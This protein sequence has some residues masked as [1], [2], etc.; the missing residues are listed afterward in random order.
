MRKL[1]MIAALMF[2]CLIPIQSYAGIGWVQVPK[3]AARSFGYCMNGTSRIFFFGSY[4]ETTDDVPWE[5]FVEI[6]H[7]LSDAPNAS[8]LYV[9]EEGK[10][11]Q[12]IC[13]LDQKFNEISGVQIG[14]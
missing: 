9:R 14:K 13:N 7:T 1:P 5:L 11:K 4:Y 3:D 2:L 12:A 6:A 10:E 8:P